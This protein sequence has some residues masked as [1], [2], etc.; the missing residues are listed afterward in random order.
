VGLATEG[1]ARTD[2]DAPMIG[3]SP[4]QIDASW[5]GVRGDITYL[6]GEDVG[7]GISVAAAGGKVD[8]DTLGRWDTDQV[9][10]A[11]KA[12]ARAGGARWE[13]DLRLGALDQDPAG[14][15]PF[16]KWF[17]DLRLA[18]SFSGG[19]YF[20]ARAA[21]YQDRWL[22]MPVARVERPLGT[23][24]LTAWAGTEPSMSLPAFREVFVAD[25]DWNVPDLTLPAERRYLDLRGGL[26][27]AEGEHAFAIGSEIHKTG[28]FRTWER[29][30]PLWHETRIDDVTGVGVTLSGAS[31]LGPLRVSGKLG[32]NSVRAEGMQVP[33]VPRYEGWFDL[34]YAYEGWR[35]GVSLEG[36]GGREDE[37][38]TSFNDFLKLDLEGAYRFRTRS[39]PIGFRNLEIAVEVQNVTDV[40]DRRW[41]GVPS[42]GVGVIAGVR[43]LYGE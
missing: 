12:A 26:R 4:A 38:G 14:A 8:A 16:R 19:W 20:G 42:Y 41:P 21:S 22:V 23:S 32:V 18:R 30:G 39:L 35:W 24:G 3:L 1:T 29:V 13:M 10:Y 2:D 27:W 34:G 15:D 37:F 11:F 9:W 36:A 31:F 5:Y 7:A 17:H 25:G 6:A 33:Y 28:E 40:K 43:A